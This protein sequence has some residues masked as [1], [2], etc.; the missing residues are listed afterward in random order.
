MTRARPN[1]NQQ[2]AAREAARNH[3]NYAFTAIFAMATL[4]LATNEGQP[5]LARMAA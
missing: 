1:N 5:A 3:A 4:N 2:A